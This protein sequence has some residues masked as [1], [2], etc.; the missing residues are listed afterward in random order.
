MAEPIK[1]YADEHIAKAVVRGLRQRG[2]DV[3]TV[4]Q[5]GLRGASDED[6]ITRAKSEGRVILTHDHDFLRLAAIV[7]DHGGIVFAHRPTPIGVVISGLMLIHQVLEPAEMV[8]K[9]EYL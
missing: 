9:V 2:V 4:T 7:P 5:A 1:Y 6:H 3:L 8:G